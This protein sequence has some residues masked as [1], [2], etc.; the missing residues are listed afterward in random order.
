MKPRRYERKMFEKEK[1]RHEHITDCVAN[2]R[3]MTTKTPHPTSLV[4]KK[5]Y[6]AAK[7]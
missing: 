4:Y 6:F 3:K 5:N 7:R 1:N 2:A